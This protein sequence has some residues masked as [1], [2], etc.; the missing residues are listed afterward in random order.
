MSRRV[1]DPVRSFTITIADSTRARLE[2]LT[3]YFRAYPQLGVRTASTNQ[4]ASVLLLQLIGMEEARLGLAGQPLHPQ[5]PAAPV[6][7]VAPAPPTPP[8]AYPLPYPPPYQYAPPPAPISGPV[9]SAPPAVAPPAVFLPGSEA[10]HAHWAHTHSASPQGPSPAPQSPPPFALDP[11]FPN[12]NELFNNRPG[13]PPPDYD[14]KAAE[15]L[16][17]IF[18]AALGNASPPRW[19]PP[20]PLGAEGSFSTEGPWAPVPGPSR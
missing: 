20:P 14:A 2:R 15:V 5:S 1:T 11:N 13:A 6:A 16:K 19:P 10:D 7:P 17:D 12:V 4:T 18:P 9:S 8:A 3:A